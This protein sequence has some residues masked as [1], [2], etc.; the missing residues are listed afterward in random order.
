M[1]GLKLPEDLKNDQVDVKILK[2]APVDP[3][4]KA[5]RRPSLLSDCWGGLK[6]HL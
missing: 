5:E 4:T 2:M 1:V 3:L 6:E